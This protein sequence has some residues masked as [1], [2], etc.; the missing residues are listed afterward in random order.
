MNTRAAGILQNIAGA[1]L[2]R[3]IARKLIK[4]FKIGD[5]DYRIH[6]GLV[7]RPYYAYC[8]LNAARLGRALGL[9]KVSVLEFGCAGGKGLLALE[10]IADIVKQETGVEVEIYGFDT[11]EGL[12]EPLDY[13]D[14]KYHWKAGFF[15]MDEQKLAPQL[16]SSKIVFGNVRD[17]VKTFFETHNPAPV[18]CMIHDLDFYSSTRDSFAILD[19][20]PERFLPRVYNYFDDIIGGEMEL[21]SDWTGERLAIDEFNASHDKAKFSPA[22]HLLA[23]PTQVRW[24]HQI[25][26]LHFFAH[27]DYDRFISKENQQIPI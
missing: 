17:T 6:A 18:A 13:R 21:Y 24:Y 12:P 23:N 2:S 7:N 26:I 10:H 11:G 3:L 4:S 14:L 9:K 27:A 25:R 16:K 19:S 15:A 8:V 22:Y 5:I 20:A 1:S